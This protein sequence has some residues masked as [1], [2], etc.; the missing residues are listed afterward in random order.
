MLACLFICVP[1]LKDKGSLSE[2]QNG[3]KVGILLIESRKYNRDRTQCK[4]MKHFCE[5]CSLFHT[6]FVLCW[7]LRSYCT[8]E[9]TKGCVLRAIT[10]LLQ[11]K[12]MREVVTCNKCKQLRFQI[13]ST[14]RGDKKNVL[15]GLF[16]RKC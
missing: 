5:F 13:A 12:P 2:E 1:L 8:R 16:H 9:T 3:M 6:C 11:K 7:G 14:L 10:Q 15:R 4:G